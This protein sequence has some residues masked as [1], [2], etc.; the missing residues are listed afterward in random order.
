MDWNEGHSYKYQVENIGPIGRLV[1]EWSVTSDG[2]KSV[3]ITNVSYRMKFGIMGAL[4][5]RLVVRRSIRKAMAQGQA[6]LKGY[7]ETREPMEMP[8]PVGTAEQAA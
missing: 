3:V 8:N 6:G 5:D 7:V 4:M 2:N 1:N